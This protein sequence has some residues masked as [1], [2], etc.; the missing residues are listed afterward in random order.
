[1]LPHLDIFEEIKKFFNQPY[2]S[3][4]YGLIIVYLT[5]EDDIDVLNHS[6]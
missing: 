5:P 2:N 6:Q 4:V 1:M 3:G